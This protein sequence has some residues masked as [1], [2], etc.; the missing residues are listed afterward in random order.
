[1]ESGKITR[2]SFSSRSCTT[3]ARPFLNNRSAFAA[4]LLAV[5][6]SSFTTNTMGQELKFPTLETPKPVASNTV[7]PPTIDTAVNPLLDV[8]K[9]AADTSNE[10]LGQFLSASAREDNAKIPQASSSAAPKLT[11]PKPA[12]F[13]P[14]T[15]LP[16]IDT[17][18]IQVEAAEIEI[19]P[20]SSLSL[21]DLESLAFEHN[22]TLAAAKARLTVTRG[23][24]VQAGLYPNPV[25]GY[26]GME[27]GIRETAGQQGGFIGQRFIT[28]GKLKLDQAAAG[29]QVT[30]A[31]FEFHAQE[32]RVLSDVRIRFYDAVTLQQRVKLTNELVRIGDE[33]V[34]ATEQLLT[35][36]QA[37]Q[38]DLLLAEIQ[39]DESRILFDNSTNEELQA[40]RRLAAVIG[41]PAM[42]PTAL[43]GELEIA[44]QQLD[45]ST[46]YATVMD[47]NP[48]L[49]AARI[50]VD[51]ARI[52]L[53][54]ARKEPVPDIDLMVSHRHHNVTNENVTTVQAG[55]P[56]PIFNRN[57]GNIRSA[58]AQLRV[59]SKDRERIELELQD[60]LAVAYRRYTN[61]L[62]QTERYRVRMI[63][64]AEKSLKLVTDGYEKGQVQY[65]TLLTAQRTYWQ[66]SLSYLDSLKELRT[67]A[68]MIEGQLLSNSLLERKQG[69]F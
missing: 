8:T 51:R 36:R 2:L 14:A 48:V 40:W 54:R 60:R 38:N 25:I 33:L 16:P 31:H 58:E 21:I 55:F 64:R 66:V 28:G 6:L 49:N 42:Q 57:Q 17:Q 52:L 43:S 45:W 26:Q 41:L 27:M 50:R 18:Q 30:A 20:T 53:Q 22:P 69:T 23:Q 19:I 11:A 67:S 12:E 15:D 46:C 13:L 68:S 10:T 39:V 63:P 56:L 32:L 24:Q 44:P 35:G 59:A 37:T 65:L 3:I 47:N 34:R 9:Q 62:Q 5:S 29:K 7:A 1:M 4:I 61:A